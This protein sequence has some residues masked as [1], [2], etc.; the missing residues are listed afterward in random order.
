MKKKFLL[1][2]LIGFFLTASSSIFARSY[3]MAGCGLGSI[4]LGSQNNFLQV[5]AATTNGTSY[6]QMFGI[7]SGTSNCTEDGVVK[8]E[9]TRE[10]F[11]RLNYES[12]EQEV[13]TGKGEKLDTL[14]SLFGCDQNRDKFQSMTK[15]NYGKLFSPDQTPSTLVLTIKNE[16]NKDEVLKSSCKI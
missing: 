3:G 11:V 9:R 5:S 14:A 8:K 6:S 12:L 4:V 2:I 13:A 10:I 7:T 1:T 15:S 16:I